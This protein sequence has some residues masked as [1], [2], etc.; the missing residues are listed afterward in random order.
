[1]TENGHKTMR[2]LLRLTESDEKKKDPSHDGWFTAAEITKKFRLKR[3]KPVM[4]VSSYLTHLKRGG[5]VER[6][7]SSDKQQAWWRLTK[8]GRNEIE[9]ALDVSA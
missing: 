6:R 8:K 2:V 3:T 1:M 5:L 9:E 7:A 4:T